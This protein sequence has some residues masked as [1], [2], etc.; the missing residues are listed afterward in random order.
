MGDCAFQKVKFTASTQGIT[1]NHCH[2]SHVQVCKWVPADNSSQKAFLTEMTQLLPDLFLLPLCAASKWQ[3]H[4]LTQ[5]TS[6][7]PDAERFALGA[8][9]NF[10]SHS[11]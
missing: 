3:P 7:Q 11:L 2:G 10:S 1:S 6:P 4:A 8:E 9:S 5:S